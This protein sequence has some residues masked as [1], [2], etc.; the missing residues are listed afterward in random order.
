[1]ELKA[2]APTKE[3]EIACTRHDQATVKKQHTQVNGFIYNDD[4]CIVGKH[5]DCWICSS[6]INEVG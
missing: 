1:M 3:D 5:P 6:D 2:N 4:H